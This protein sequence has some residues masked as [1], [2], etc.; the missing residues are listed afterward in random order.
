MLSDNPKGTVVI[1][2]IEKLQKSQQTELL[3]LINTDQLTCRIICTSCADIDDL[4]RVQQF[5]SS[6]Y[7]RLGVIRYDLPCLKDRAE[8][9]PIL[10]NEF[11]T[12][13]K[14]ELN[15]DIKNDFFKMDD[16]KNFP[17]YGNVKQL[18]TAVEWMVF[19]QSSKDRNGAVNYHLPFHQ[20]KESNIIE[21]SHMK[22][23]QDD[24]FM[25]SLL[26]MTLK[27][28]RETFESNY[29]SYILE[30]F[31]GNIA[32]MASFIDMDRTALHR[33]LKAMDITFE[34]HTKAEHS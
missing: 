2:A 24:P 11:L 4:V 32:R 22:M 8:D 7:D 34:H 17:W 18:K 31:D 16:I 29:L 20:A 25:E 26:N 9:I 14:E 1:E 33:K 6:L 28:A 10:I 13:Y 3:S 27:E 23:Q 15:I 19:C 12:V 30:K 5:S 21:Y